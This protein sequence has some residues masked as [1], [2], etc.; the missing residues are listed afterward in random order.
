MKK[1]FQ[2]LCCKK[3][4]LH[5]ELSF[6]FD[7]GSFLCV[8]CADEIRKSVSYFMDGKSVNV[9]PYCSGLEYKDNGCDLPYACDACP[10]S[11]SDCHNKCEVCQG[12]GR[13]NY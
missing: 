9:C 10:I 5:K 6:M 12:T 13:L 2:C 11:E 4:R 8:K 1:L 3:H 7:D